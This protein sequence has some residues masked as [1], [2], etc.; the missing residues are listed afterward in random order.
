MEFLLPPILRNQEGEIRKAGFEIEFAEIDLDTA[1][2]CITDIFGGR[3]NVLNKFSQEVTETKYGDFSLSIDI[4]FLTQKPYFKLWEKMGIDPQE[5]YFGD[6][7]IEAN[8]ENALDSI[9][10]TVIPYEIGTPPIPFT[11]LEVL[12]EL[13]IALYQKN[14]KGTSSS[15]L[16][17]FATHINPELPKCDTETVLNYTK[18][19]LLLYPWLAEKIGINFTRKL[20]PFINPFPNE[21]VGLL[22]DINYKPNLKKFIH[23]YFQYNPDRNRPLDLYPVFAYMDKPAVTYLKNIGKVNARPTLHYRIPNSLID[24]PSWSLSKEWNLWIE[25]EKLASDP[26]EIKKLSVEYKQINEETILGFNKKWIKRINDW[27]NGD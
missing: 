7:S 25:I 26:L 9:A 5:I 18:A 4:R 11:E 10:S 22:L 16:Y 3:V 14:A 12:E 27:M 15:M 2:E 6:K 19:F 13:R 21:Y 24:D 20:T 23:D 8:L 1:A 17:A